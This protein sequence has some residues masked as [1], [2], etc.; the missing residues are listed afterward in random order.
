MK[1]PERGE[2]SF[3]DGDDQY[4]LKLS[5]NAM[6]SLEAHYDTD[7]QQVFQLLDPGKGKSARITDV[8]RLFSAMILP[9]VDD[10]KAGNLM[11]TVG[12]KRI[13]E[14]LAESASLAV[15]EGDGNE[16]KT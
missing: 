1:N 4:V 8:R 7:I 9:E 11:D 13:S 12:L 14:L 6:C 15:P 2:V 16:G 5:T 3:T 10:K